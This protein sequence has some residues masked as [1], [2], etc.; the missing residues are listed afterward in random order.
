MYYSS[1]L[2]IFYNYKKVCIVVLYCVPVLVMS[3]CLSI[4]IILIISP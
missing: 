1:L 2:Y 4:I 3:L